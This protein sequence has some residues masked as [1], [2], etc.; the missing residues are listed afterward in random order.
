MRSPRRVLW[1]RVV[2]SKVACSGSYGLALIFNPFE[3][4][5][6]PKI[7]GN[8]E[9]LGSGHTPLPPDSILVLD[10]VYEP[11]G[12]GGGLGESAQILNDIIAS[13]GGERLNVNP[14]QSW[15]R[16][17]PSVPSS[18]DSI[19]IQVNVDPPASVWNWSIH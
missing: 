18:P 17:D 19:T 3:P 16:E 10:V 5:N 13:P 11:D 4:R 8:V 1:L 12:S 6:V 9:I 15:Y 7:T 2:C 14:S